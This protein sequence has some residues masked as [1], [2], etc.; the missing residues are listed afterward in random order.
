MRRNVHIHI[1]TADALWDES[2][3]ARNHGQFAS[4]THATTASAT[5]E[6]R[7]RHAALTAQ[8]FAFHRAESPSTKELHNHYTHPDGRT[9]TV[10]AHTD[11][12]TGQ[13]TITSRITSGSAASPHV[14]TMNQ[15]KAKS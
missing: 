9:A 15:G 4:T 7:K 5:Q 11:P 14:N 10:S 3:H 1:H 12:A 13:H 6:Q 2:K 8:G